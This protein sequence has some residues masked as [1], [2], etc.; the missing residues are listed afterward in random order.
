VWLGQR[1]MKLTLRWFDGTTLEVEAAL[2]EE[3]FDRAHVLM[4]DVLK[5]EH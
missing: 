3:M 4:L 5:K 2:T 1:A